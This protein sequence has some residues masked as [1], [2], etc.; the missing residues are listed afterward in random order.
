MSGKPWMALLGDLAAAALKPVLGKRGFAAG[1]IVARWRAIV[2]AEIAAVS[3]PERI[4]WRRGRTDGG[5]PLPGVLVLRVARAHAV[6]VQHL[7]GLIIERVNAYFG[8]RAVGSLRLRQVPLP[9]AEPEPP[10]TAVPLGADTEA[11][12]GEAL[13][14]IA[15]DGLRGALQ[16]LGRA[17]LGR[18]EHGAA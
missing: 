11:A 5:E 6:D 15:D 7:S 14:P 18:G 9:P 4:V 10:A 13:S 16:R 2:G 17:A 12:L 1:E 3:A 8:Y